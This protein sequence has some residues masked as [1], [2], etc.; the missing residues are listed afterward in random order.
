MEEETFYLTKEQRAEDVDTT[1]KIQTD[2]LERQKQEDKQQTQRIE[3]E[4][5]KQQPLKKEK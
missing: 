2:K 1:K 4:K 5:N 3:Q